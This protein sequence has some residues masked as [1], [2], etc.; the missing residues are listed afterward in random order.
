MECYQRQDP[1]TG[2]SAGEDPVVQQIARFIDDPA[3]GSFGRLARRAF[4]FQF[5]RIAPYRRL[6]LSRGVTP[7]SLTDWR[8]VPAIPVA[9]FKTLELRA[10]PARE[11]FRSSGTT[12]SERSV[13]AHPFPDLYRRVIDA[14]F[15]A[16]CLHHLVAGGRPPMLALVPS[17]RQQPDSSLSFMIDHVLRHF[18]AGEKGGDDGGSYAFGP[19]GVDVARATA[20]CEERLR[21]GRGGLILATSFALAQWLD[22]LAA[23][24]LSFRLPATTT[25]FDTGGF[26]GRSRE[27]T[28]V[29]LAQRLERHLG[30]APDRIVREY[31]MTELTSHF[32]TAALRGGD[33]ELFEG[34]PWLKARV[35]DPE[36]LEERPA[37]QPGVLAIF[38]LANVGSAVHLLTQDLGVVH[39]ERFR[40]LGRASGA[41]LRGCSLTVE[42]LTAAF[43]DG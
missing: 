32:Y 18:G 4:A 1:Q 5:R 13:H 36:T 24:G 41:D 11:I 10:A 37:G 40:L 30:I 17:R 8:H 28:R 3:A 12:G 43:G 15:P 7:Q 22:E 23:Q 35:V 6:C 2:V 33:P 9:A 26:K 14:T 25:V 19:R 20:W 29:E 27:L 39:G 21:D 31:G 34:P 16:H 38:D 42:R